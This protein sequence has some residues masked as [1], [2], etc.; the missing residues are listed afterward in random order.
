MTAPQGVAIGARWVP[1]RGRRE[2][3][4]LIRQIHRPDRSCAVVLDDGTRR[5]IPWTLLRKSWKHAA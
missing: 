2:L 3:P 1:K 4:L 5:E